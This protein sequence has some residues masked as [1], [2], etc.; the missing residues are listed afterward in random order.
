MRLHFLGANRQV[1]GSR[2]CLE[3]GQSRVMVDCGLFQE[4]P[5]VDRNWDPGPLDPSSV[6]AML[7][8]HAHLDHCGLLPRFVANGFSGPIHCTPPTVALAE[9]IMTDSAKIQE[10]DAEYKKRRHRREKRKGAHPEVP[11]YTQVE[12]EKTLPRMQKHDYGRPIEVSEGILATF[13]DAGHILGSAMIECEL[14]FEGKTRHVVFSGD[15]GQWDKPFIRDPTMFDRADYVV[16]ESTCGDRQHPDGGSIV[17]Q[18]GDV[19]NATIS[20]EATLSFLRLP[21]SARRSCCST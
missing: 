18:L 17:D 11:L 2:Y 19:I 1:T 5:F 14:S 16:M 7:L 21:L 13:H 3:V 8:T 15:T 10:E 6:D 20:R 12:V 4:R 9:V